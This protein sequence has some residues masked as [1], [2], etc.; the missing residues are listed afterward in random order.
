M[1]YNATSKKEDIMPALARR[2][3]SILMLAALAACS[4][5]TFSVG[6]DFNV[7]QFTT[8]VQRGTTTS[9]QV[10]S[11][12]G[13]PNGTG[14]RVETDG[15]RYDEWTYYFASGNFSDVSAT[16]LKTLQIKFD[17]KGI[18]EGY[19]WSTPGH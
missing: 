1:R 7:S 17:E 15:K 5:T 19:N 11:W 14:K 2:I 16:K 10:K 4:A 13:A 18:V 6:S 8:R 12:L 9:E 3:F